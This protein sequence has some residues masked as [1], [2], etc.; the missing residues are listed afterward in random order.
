MTKGQLRIT[1]IQHSVPITPYSLLLYSTPHLLI[2]IFLKK[3]DKY[4]DT[5][6]C[7]F[8]QAKTQF[9]TSSICG[10]IFCSKIEKKIIAAMLDKSP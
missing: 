7:L 3:N 6:E 5:F 9:V 8:L 10:F 2:L 4:D 1:P